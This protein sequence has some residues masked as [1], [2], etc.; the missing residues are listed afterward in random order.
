[1]SLLREWRGGVPTDAK[2]SASE[3]ARGVLRHQLAV[4]LSHAPGTRAGDDPEELHDMRVAVRRMRAAIQLYGP[5]GVGV[6]DPLAVDLGPSL[7]WL[8]GVLGPVRDLDVQLAQLS[9]WRSEWELDCSIF[10][11]VIDER[12]AERRRFERR[13]MVAHLDSEAYRSLIEVAVRAL[14]GD[15]VVALEEASAAEPTVAE[16]TPQVLMAAR[17]RVLRAGDRISADSSSKRYHRCRVRAKVLRYAIEF[18]A[19]FLGKP[20]KRMLRMLRRLQDVLG[21]HQ[22]AD[23][24]REHL[25]GVL[26]G[27]L[28]SRTAFGL[29]VLDERYRQL[30]EELRSE[31]PEPYGDLR[32]RAWKDLRARAEK[33]TR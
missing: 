10:D 13:R 33:R 32:G 4:A 21:E 3:F 18:H 9:S 15:G 27:E 31:F 17:R 29:G 20:A 12:W 22:D 26:D 14:R 16:I 30:G 5:A 24:A 23:V 28:P 11:P 8:G 2:M 7:R 6:L 1:M 25:R 19:S